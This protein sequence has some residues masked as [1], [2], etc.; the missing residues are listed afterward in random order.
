LRGTAYALLGPTASG[1]SRLALEAASR[2]PIEIVSVDSAQVYRGMDIGT[3]KPSAA[4]RARV[5][6]HLVDLLDPVERYS[7]G[8]FRA[9]AIRAIRA[10]LERNK[11]PLLVGGT[12]LYYRS[13]AAGLDELPAA[14]VQV[15]AAIDAE[16]ARRGW[17]GLHA[18]LAA[19]DPQAAQRIAPN[20][21]QRIQRALEVFRVA[22]KP[23]SALQR[24]AADPLPFAIKG[25]ALVP[26][27]SELHANIERRFD[28]MLA[29][30]LVE[31][32]RALRERYRLSA[33]TPSMRAV[34]Y[35]QVWEFLEGEC[36]APTMR[37][38]AIA[39]TRQLAKR[40]LTWLRSFPGLLRLDASRL[41]DAAAAFHG[42]LTRSF[43]R[44]GY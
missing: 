11:L 23:I 27:R 25:C 19:V 2:L 33:D 3:A 32:V 35:R 39:A 38:R 28:A 18:E 16:A 30:G 37:S 29:T 8:R 41:D 1:K 9:D 24:G 20:D 43:G 4:E 31:E 17:P 10:I 12:M 13:L 40:Q 15:R 7:T 44:R 14:D 34:G 21:A 42:L 26:E 5:P 6:H 22:G 36:D